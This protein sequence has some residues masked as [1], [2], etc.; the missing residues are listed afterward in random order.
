MTTDRAPRVAMLSVHTSPL[1]QPGTGDAGGMNVYVLELAHALAARGARV[2]VFTRATRSDLPETVVL[3][4]TDAS[5]RPLSAAASRDVLLADDV[6]PGVTPP[7]L[8]HHIPAGP[9]E[10]LD[11]ND[12]PGVLCGMAAGVLRSEAARRPG[13]YDVVHSHYW[14]SG[15]VGAIAAQRWE[16]PLVHTAHTLAKVKNTNLGPGDA[17]EPS[18]RIVGEEQV[19]A[20][21]DALVAST[22]VEAAELVDL[23]GAD[24]ARVHV[25]EPG[26]DLERFRP[27]GPG[28]QEDARRRLGLPVDR[29][30]VLFAGRVQPLKAPDVLVRALGELRASGR[31]VPLLAVLGGPS[32]RPTA[33]RELRALA[34]TLGVDDDVLVRPPAPRDELARWYRA[35]DLVAMPSR[36][37]SFGLVAVEAQASGTPVLAAAV[38]GLRTVV[39]DGVSGRLVQGHDPHVWADAIADALADDARRARWAVGARQVAERYAWS[40]AADQVLKVYAIA[41]EPRHGA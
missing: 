21:A 39:D 30:V 38:G 29:P 7:V 18:V 1:D 23:Y 35:A 28:A 36:S 10:A 34:V 40:T 14:L 31:P 9:F 13:W 20:D 26:V 17:A 32:G 12:L 24:P 5:G 37:E 19:V 22:P 15:Q 33:V 8:V 4:G 16:V 27:G 25:V 11:K 41:A 2:E 6:P 3:D